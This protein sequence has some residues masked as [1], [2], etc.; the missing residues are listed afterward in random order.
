MSCLFLLHLTTVKLNSFRV[1]FICDLI[2][3]FSRSMRLFLWSYLSIIVS[4]VSSLCHHF[5]YWACLHC[6]F[7]FSYYDYLFMV[8]ASLSRNGVLKR[9]LASFVWNSYFWNLDPFLAKISL[10][11]A[12]GWWGGRPNWLTR[13]YI[14]YSQRKKGCWRLEVRAEITRKFVGC[15]AW[16]RLSLKW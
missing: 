7:F 10:A 9:K 13:T 8:I 6:N 16:E 2:S 12:G 14:V 3:S 11:V 4:S 15:I 1:F 5:A